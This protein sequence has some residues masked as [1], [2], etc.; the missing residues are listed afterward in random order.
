VRGALEKGQAHPEIVQRT[1]ALLC[2]INDRLGKL[3]NLIARDTCR[4]GESITPLTAD[5][6]DD[7]QQV[8]RKES[9]DYEQAQIEAA[10][11]AR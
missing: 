6:L 1:D 4:S 9:E 7:I 8:L 3:V 10:R 5:Y 2:S 11:E